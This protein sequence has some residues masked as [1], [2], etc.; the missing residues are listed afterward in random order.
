MPNTQAGRH[1]GIIYTFGVTLLNPIIWY[2]QKLGYIVHVFNL[3]W[4]NRPEPKPPDPKKDLGKLWRRRLK[5]ML[6]LMSNLPQFAM[7]SHFDEFGFCTMSS[8]DGITDSCAA[9]LRSAIR[10]TAQVG[11]LNQIDGIQAVCD[12]GASAISTY[13]A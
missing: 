6:L 3:A 2:L 9:C 4:T 8:T 10:D 12:T 5:Q 1:V 11:L 13:D 7:S